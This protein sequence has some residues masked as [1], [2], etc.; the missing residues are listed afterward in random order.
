[1]LCV[2]YRFSTQFQKR[3][4]QPVSNKSPI[5]SKQLGLLGELWQQ[6]RLAFNLMVDRDVPLYLKA[7]PI[8]AIAYLIMPFDFLPDVV[9][10]LGQLDDLTILILG[11]KMFIELAPQDVVKRYIAQYGGAQA[12]GPTIVD[13]QQPDSANYDS[14]KDD[15]FVEGIIIDDDEVK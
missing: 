12:K 10:G 7:L 5:S 11:A 6:A 8:A 3:T 4:N 9:P 1:M 2:A 15:N 14:P 13:A